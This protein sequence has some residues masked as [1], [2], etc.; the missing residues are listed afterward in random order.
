MS[1]DNIWI[2]TD[3]SKILFLLG[4]VSTG[5]TLYRLADL[6]ILSF[7]FVA[8]V[9][10]LVKGHSIE[11]FLAIVFISICILC[12]AT[13][14][15]LE[16]Y[17][18][19]HAGMRALMYFTMFP[20]LVLFFKNLTV[21]FQ[22]Y[23]LRFLLCYLVLL[24]G[25][26]VWNY[27]YSDLLQMHE[28]SYYI[29]NMYLPEVIRLLIILVIV[30]RINIYFASL[31]LVTCII[32]SGSTQT[33]VI[34][35]FLLCIRLSGS[36]LMT[37]LALPLFFV[38]IIFYPFILFL[39]EP[40]IVNDHNF[41]VRLIS[42]RNALSLSLDGNL[43]TPFI[44]SLSLPEIY[45]FSGD[46]R[47]FNHEFTAK[48]ELIGVHNTLTQVLFFFTIF[49]LISFLGF[50]LY[51]LKDVARASADMVAVK[52]CML[53]TLAISLSAN[54]AVFS[55]RYIVATAILIGLS[56]AVNFNIEG[57]ANSRCRAKRCLSQPCSD[58]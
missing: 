28:I 58:D 31:I 3:Q 21:S 40:I 6:L 54:T 22:H 30:F 7:C 8:S 57:N 56:S 55:L 2:K 9:F 39:L 47:T 52:I 41:Y 15:V 10:G 53:F 11:R 48:M 38:S 44:G 51:V 29:G 34:Y 25:L 33:I 23:S 32:L 5:L 12:F 18:N 26:I 46:Y 36:G 14:Y 4:I 37:K 16:T 1:D 13:T 24:S 20:G 42:I 49:G 17:T 19:I 27:S 50:M 43:I 35:F 45:V